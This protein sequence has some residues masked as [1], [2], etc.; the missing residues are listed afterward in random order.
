MNIQCVKETFFT[1]LLE[2]VITYF[3]SYLARN[4]AFLNYT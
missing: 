4:H 3:Q 1:P 2:E